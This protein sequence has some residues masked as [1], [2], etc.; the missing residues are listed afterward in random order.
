MERELVALLIDAPATLAF[1]ESLTAGLA[2]ATVAQVP[3]ASAVLRGGLVTYAT[4]L[5]ESLAGVPHAV[6]EANGPVSPV[7]ARAMAEGARR[8]CGSD[9]GVALTGVAGPDP[10]DGHPVGEVWVGIAGPRRSFALA[11]GGTEPL[12]GSRQD[13]REAAVGAALSALYNEV[14]EQTQGEDR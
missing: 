7:T 10:Q 11:A 1:C 4:D 8:V 6:L 13:I 12:R 2:A 9:Y 5:K 3:G 14:R